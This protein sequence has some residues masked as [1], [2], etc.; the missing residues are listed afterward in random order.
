MLVGSTAAAEQPAQPDAGPD[1]ELLE[2]L[3]TLVQA[4]DNKWV[5]PEDMRGATEDPDASIVLDDDAPEPG[6]IDF[7]RVN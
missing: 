1:I 2:Y 3:G 6:T 4:R 5:G 7:E